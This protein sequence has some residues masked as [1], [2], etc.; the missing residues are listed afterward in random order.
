M[1]TCQIVSN[2]FWISEI[3]RYCAEMNLRILQGLVLSSARPRFSAT[4][5]TL[6]IFLPLE[7]DSLRKER[8]QTSLFRCI[9]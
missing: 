1:V 6:D 3:Q 9:K 8:M 4:E 2:T 7:Q 5:L